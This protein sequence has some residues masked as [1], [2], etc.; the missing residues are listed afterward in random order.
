MSEF[1][2][3]IIEEDNPVL[4]LNWKTEL[5]WTAPLSPSLKLALR[6]ISH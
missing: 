6:L 3:N 5:L 1:E 4:H 2:D